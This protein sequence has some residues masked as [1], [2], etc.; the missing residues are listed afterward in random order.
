MN[1]TERARLETMRKQLHLLF[2]DDIRV[3]QITGP[4]YNMTHKRTFFGRILYRIKTFK[5]LRR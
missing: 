3:F 5:I 2:G 1:K 4:L